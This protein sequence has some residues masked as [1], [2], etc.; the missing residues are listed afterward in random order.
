MK[1]AGYV[2]RMRT[3]AWS[4]NLMRIYQPDNLEV[5]RNII[6]NWISKKQDRGCELGSYGSGQ[7]SVAGSCEFHSGPFRKD[8]KLLI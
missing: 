6:L 7:G 4:E 3:N 8:S 1:W 5:D 2:A